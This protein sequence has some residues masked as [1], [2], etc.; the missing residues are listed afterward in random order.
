MKAKLR[1]GTIATGFQH[2]AQRIGQVEH[3]LAGVVERTEQPASQAVVVQVT[4][5]PTCV[6]IGMFLQ[7]E[8]VHRHG[9]ATARGGAAQDAR[10][11][12]IVDREVFALRAC[13]PTDEVIQEIVSEGRG[14]ATIAYSFEAILILIR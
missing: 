3:G 14:G 2:A 5:V 11:R 12:G 6:E 13:I 4:F 10:A 8:G 1:A 9:G 7:P